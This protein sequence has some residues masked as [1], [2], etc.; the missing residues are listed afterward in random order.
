MKELLKEKEYNSTC[1]ILDEKITERETRKIVSDTNPSE[2]EVYID[3]SVEIGLRNED[4]NEKDE[5]LINKEKELENFE[6]RN[7][8][9]VGVGIE[10]ATDNVM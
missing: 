9:G 2:I 7:T 5:V 1:P 6:E 3:G 4:E 8:C 10:I